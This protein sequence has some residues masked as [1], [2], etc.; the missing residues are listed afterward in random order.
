MR[1]WLVC[2]GGLCLPFIIVSL[3][4]IISFSVPCIYTGENWAL[5]IIIFPLWTKRLDHM[6]VALCWVFQ[7]SGECKT[8]S[9]VHLAPS[10]A[11]EMVLWVFLDNYEMWSPR[12]DPPNVA[13]SVQTKRPRGIISIWGHPQY[14]PAYRQGQ[15]LFHLFLRMYWYARHIKNVIS[16]K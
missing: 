2:L 5:K 3:G 7:G 1:N 14:I 6:L 12:Q 4:A 16:W 9:I 11:Q 13:I 15:R 8:I 10:K